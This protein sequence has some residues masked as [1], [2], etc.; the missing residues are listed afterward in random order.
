MGDLLK[1]LKKQLKRPVY[2]GHEV[3]NIERL[4]TR[5]ANLDLILGGGLPKGRVIQVW[6]RESAGKSALCLS[7]IKNRQELN[8]E[9]EYLYIDAERTINE[10]DLNV[11]EIDKDRFLL[12]KPDGGED[13][14]D[15]AVNALNLGAELVVVDS[16]P[17]LRPKRVLDEIMSNSEYRDVAGIANLLERVQNKITTTLD[18]T[19]GNIIFINQERPA[20]DIYSG[21]VHS[22]GSALKFMTSIS[23]HI[24]G[25]KKDKS[26]PSRIIQTVYTAKNKTHTPFQTASIQLDNRKA[27]KGFSLAEAA[28]ETEVLKLKGGGYIVATDKYEEVL[29]GKHYPRSVDNCSAFLDENIEEFNFL[30]DVVCNAALENQKTF[31]PLEVEPLDEPD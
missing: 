30:Y 3:R 7:L 10:D 20:K 24:K 22:G 19:N 1:F 5:L 25:V 6:G 12:Y 9:G 2:T 27:S 4:E 16:I 28:F 21:A 23:L 8:P 31:Q 17:F 26:N 13:A 29:K 14:I 11:H 15:A 18:D